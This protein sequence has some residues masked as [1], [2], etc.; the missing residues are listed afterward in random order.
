MTYRHLNLSFGLY[1]VLLVVYLI[2]FRGIFFSSDELLLFDMTESAARHGNLDETLTYSLSPQRNNTPENLFTS[3]ESYEPLQPILAAPLF[4]VAQLAPDMNLMHGVWLFNVLITP[5]IAV[6]FFWGGQ[7]MGYNQHVSWWGALA[8][9]V[10]TLLFPYSRTFFREP[11]M[12]L[13]ITAALVIT[14][15]I[16]KIRNR[17]PWLELLALAVVFLLSTLTK[18]V[19]IL[20]LPIIA[21]LLFRGKWQ[22]VVLLAGAGLVLLLLL[23]ILE[24]AGFAGGNRFA[25]SRWI[26]II[27]DT[28]WQWVSES[29]RG[30]L[31]SPGRSFFVFSPILLLSPWGMWL[32]WKQGKWRLVLGTIGTFLIFAIG[33]G[34]FRE[35]FWSGGIS[36]GP[37]YL[38]PLIPL[39]ML[40]ILP[41]IN[42]V[43]VSKNMMAKAIIVFAVLISFLNQIIFSMNSESFYY[44]TLARQGVVGFEGGIWEIEF[45]PIV[46]YI[47]YATL[48]DIPILWRYHDFSIGFIAVITLLAGTGMLLNYRS[49]QSNEGKII[50]SSTL[51]NASAM[52]GV[53]SLFFVF[54]NVVDDPRF[55]AENSDAPLAIEA[56]EVLTHEDD[57]IVLKDDSLV[58]PFA[59]TYTKSNLIVTLPLAPGELYSNEHIPLVANGSTAQL[60]GA[61]TVMLYQYLAETH[62]RVWLVTFFGPFHN[63]ARRPEERYLAENYFPFARI[64]LS[65]DMYLVGA[66]LRP[67][68]DPAAPPQQPTDFIFG[69]LFQLNG[70]SLPEGGVYTTGDAIPVTLNIEVLRAVDRDYTI[71]LQLTDT[72]G[73]VVAQYDAFPLG[74]FGRTTE[75][76]TGQTYNESRGV[77]LPENLAAGTYT[78]Q[79]VMYYW[80]T[81]ERLELQGE[82]AT[83][84]NVAILQKVTIQ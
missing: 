66:K 67:Q 61:E 16:Q 72:G 39:F 62:D 23:V 46:Q 63:F 36:L 12:T 4:A 13:F 78:L 19:S 27:T 80:E 48:D 75:W 34:F 65:E 79:I 71:A 33:Y 56:L 6:V 28:E 31:Y 35:G 25:P 73:N 54:L 2:F 51:Y 50:K 81:L 38:L 29:F 59:A 52:V 45:A 14:L 9:G 77:L 83:P 74:G 30:Y 3:L 18:E 7:M 57:V 47:R 76:Q 43:F 37:R 21:L 64:R 58:L 26:T 1:F 10:T 44:E 32:L 41:L 20:F 11:L 55:I 15:R 69:D 68:S 84:T 60:A 49:L 70:Y 82:G 17:I 40:T 22:N 24:Q 53:L 8:L 42:E 5:L